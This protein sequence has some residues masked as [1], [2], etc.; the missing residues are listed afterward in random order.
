M[1]RNESKVMRI[2]SYFLRFGRSLLTQ[3]RRQ[4]L[5]VLWRR[6]L[7]R[8]ELQSLGP[9]FLTWWSNTWSSSVFHGPFLTC[10]C[11]FF[12][13]IFLLLLLQVILTYN[14]TRHTTTLINSTTI[15]W[16]VLY[17]HVKCFAFYFV[18]FCFP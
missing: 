2:W 9:Y 13:C 11:S 12:P 7:D 3:R 15:I 8:M 18:L 4:D 6:P 14:N 10:S 17:Y 16:F 5:P 1:W